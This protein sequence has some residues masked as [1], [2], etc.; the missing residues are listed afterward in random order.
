MD[1]YYMDSYYFSP[2]KEKRGETALNV[3]TVTEAFPNLVQ[4]WLVNQLVQIEKQ[5]GD[6]RIISFRE[7]ELPKTL[8][9]LSGLE[10]KYC[11]VGNDRPSLLNF[12]SKN[13]FRLSS[14]RSVATLTK[15]YIVSG[16]FCRP[17]KL[18]FELMSSPAFC[19]KPDL[20]HSHAEKAADKLNNL[21]RALGVPHVVTFHGLPPADV[22]QLTIKGRQQFANTV[23]LVFVN[24]E[25]AKQHY[26][27]LGGPEDKVQVVPQGVD[28]TQWHY[29]PVSPPTSTEP[30]Q[31]LTVGR[32]S[33]EKGHKYVI[34][35]LCLLSKYGVNVQYHIVGRGPEG[36]RLEK[37]VKE[38]GLE[39]NVVFHGILKGEELR[40]R[41]V[42]SHIFI[43]PS[44]K[45]NGKAEETQGVVIQEAQASGVLVI[46]TNTGGIPECLDNG[47]SGFVVPD[48]NAYAIAEMVTHLFSRKSEWPL[49][50]AKARKWVE[51]YYCADKIGQK[52]NQYYRLAIQNY[53]QSVA[54][55]LVESNSLLADD[56]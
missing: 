48:K 11:C 54:E 34:N 29:Q 25:F 4:P 32:L 21:I 23:D 2:F 45:G 17:K 49:I 56:N 15:Y 14:L 8:V 13:V 22:T 6:N 41:Y 18:L 16:R 40:Q 5:G 24:T 1:E 42:Q 35:A 20:V 27:S 12:F 43:L 39:K 37:Q 28:L 52:M 33:E 51:T 53:N 50:Q 30:L 19:V 10:Q 55:Q 36:A 31:L 7:E 38:L 47:T 3:L 26:I 44:I 46:G 9:N